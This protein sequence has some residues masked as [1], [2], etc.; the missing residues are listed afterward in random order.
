MEDLGLGREAGV[1]CLALENDIHQL[2]VGRVKMMQKVAVFG[3]AG[4]VKSRLRS[5]K[6]ADIAELLRHVLDKIQYRA[7]GVQVSDEEFQQAHLQILVTEC[8]ILDGFGLL[9]MFWERLDAANT[10]NYLD[11][12]LFLNFLRVMKRLISGLLP[13]IP[14]VR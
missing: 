5:R 4:V 1:T 2:N 12:P 13:Y 3:D 14:Q 9:K 7:G 8:W 10:L 6:L 11:L